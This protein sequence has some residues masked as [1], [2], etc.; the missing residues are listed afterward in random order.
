MANGAQRLRAGSYCT[1]GFGLEAVGHRLWL[2]QPLLPARRDDAGAQGI[3][4]RRRRPQSA[5]FQLS[6]AAI[7]SA[8][9]GLRRLLCRGLCR[10]PYHALFS[11]PIALGWP[12]YLVAVLGLVSWAWRGSIPGRALL[13]GFL[14]Y[15]LIA[16]SGKLVFVRYVLPLVP[17]LC[18]AAAD[19]LDRWGQRYGGRVFAWGLAVAIALPVAHASWQHDRLLARRDTRVLAAEW[20]EAHIQPGDHIAL[21]GVSDCDFVRLHQT[22]AQLQRTLEEQRAAGMT[23]QRLERRLRYAAHDRRPAYEIDEYRVTAEQAGGLFDEVAAT[24]VEWLV[25]HER[26]TQL[27][28]WAVAVPESLSVAHFDR[29]VRSGDEGPVYDPLD[30]F[31]VPLARFGA[32]ERPG[33]R[34][35]IYRIAGDARSF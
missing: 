2:V 32:V 24:G 8:G 5:L 11:L 30:A 19:L 1:D 18:L 23:A 25:V 16:G 27:G 3:S 31:H 22:A 14:C 21:C 20:I 4:H 33:P 15:Y 6:L 28:N 13:L 26:A 29:F 17:L 10:W 34:I 35:R 7:L 12:L 9:V